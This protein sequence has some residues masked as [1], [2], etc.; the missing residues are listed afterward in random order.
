MTKRLKAAD[1]FCGAGGTSTGL[2]RAAVKLGY[3]DIDLLAVNH[4]PVAI[5]SHSANH[6][7][8]RHMCQT[9]ESI[10]PRKAVPG[11]YLDILCASPECQG[12][13]RARGGKPTTD[14]KRSSPMQVLGWLEALRVESIVIENV[15]EF[16]EWGPLGADG[17]P[18]KSRKGEL[19]HAWLTMLRALNYSFEY[20][21]LCCADYGDPTTRERF[22]LIGRRGNKKIHW[23]HPTHKPKDECHTFFET[24]KAWRPAREIINWDKKGRSIFGRKKPLAENTM[25]RIMAGIHKF[26]GS[27]FII[28]QQSGSVPRSVND[29]V[30]TV[31]TGGAISLVE[32]FII[33]MRGSGSAHISA[34]AKSMNEPIGAVTA[35]GNHHG[36]VEPF[37]I[38]TNHAGG[39]RCHD[40]D[41]PLPTVTGAHRGEMALI[42]P[43]L[44]QTD[45][46]GSNGSCVRSID[47]PVPTLVT[48]QNVALVQPF[49]TKFY[50]TGISKS[51][52]EPLDTVTTKD[53]FG[54]VE[55]RVQDAGGELR[56]E[57]LFRMLD[58]DELA[59]AQ[60]FPKGYIFAGETKEERIMLI[61][62]AVPTNTS[63]ALCRAV[64]GN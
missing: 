28:G 42:E 35:G 32:P 18:L 13:S 29:P 58:E 25:K 19:F 31:A 62:N 6:A 39:D 10:D 26:G 8:A 48:K 45:Q 47:R 46:T 15:P 14:Q 12:F 49:V 52:E 55:P 20:K 11:G 63:E 51:V 36:L 53:R 27:A 41:N 44:I 5:K 34:S 4:W 59:L 61:G 64:L 33:S 30:M 2:L 21:V 17:K 54:L 57:V 3:N 22:F 38:H 37:L 43:F 7:N 23:P 1:L 40:L 9:V 50:G 56:L 24:F 16:V 60:G